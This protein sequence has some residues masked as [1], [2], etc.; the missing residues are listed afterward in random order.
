MSICAFARDGS[1]VGSAPLP[2]QAVDVKL[3]VRAPV[4]VSHTTSAV[5][6]GLCASATLGLISAPVAS[7]SVTASAAMRR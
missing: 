3:I 5:I 7:A 4:T 1:L 6:S 2:A